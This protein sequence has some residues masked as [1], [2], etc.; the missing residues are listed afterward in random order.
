MMKVMNMTEKVIVTDCD[1]VL[2]NWEYAFDC[3]MNDKGYTKVK[4]SEFDYDISIRYNITRERGREYIRFFNESAAIGF[5]PA[6]RD[7]AHYVKL[8][9]EKHGYVFDVVTSL[10]KSPYAA[11][12]RER[13]L[14]K[15]FGKNA[16]RNVVCLDTG[17]DKYLHLWEKYAGK[18]L[19][20][21]EDKPENAMAGKLVGMKPILIEHV[22]NMNNEDFPLAKDWEDVYNIITDPIHKAYG[23]YGRHAK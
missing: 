15:V 17:A 3:W 14:K 7:A 5:L 4:G 16:F 6:L 2:L 19:F 23:V 1:G 20:W 11:K 10:S 22:H 18:D 21:L 8:L 13:N 9:H 12:L